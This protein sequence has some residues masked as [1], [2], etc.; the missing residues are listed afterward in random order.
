MIREI[1]IV[2]CIPNSLQ[3]YGHKN[4]TVSDFGVGLAAAKVNQ[5]NIEQ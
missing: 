2:C 4:L 1:F 5:V 3:L